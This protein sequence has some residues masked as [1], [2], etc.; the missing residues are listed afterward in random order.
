[1]LPALEHVVVV[2][3]HAPHGTVG[4]SDFL[5]KGQAVREG[6]VDARID[7]VKPDD[8]SDILFTSGTT[9]RP[10]GAMCTHAQTLRAY[11]DWA[12][13]V[14][15]RAGDRYLIVNPFF[16]TFG[17]K[18][19][20]VASL[21]TGATI[22][23]QAVLDP[24][25]VLARIPTDRVSTLPGPPTLYQTLLHHPELAKHHISSLRLAV[26]RAATIPAALIRTM[27][28]DPGS[29]TVIPGPG[30]TEA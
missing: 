26:T 21:V 8:L 16:H 4:W 7:V 15:L 20:I 29:E 25:A 1:D 30:P 14:G 10:K 22:L 23:P 24:A 18:A 19:G 9:G 3:G 12:D 13:V 6:D 27:R 2:R 28:T 5:G 11:T 17:Y